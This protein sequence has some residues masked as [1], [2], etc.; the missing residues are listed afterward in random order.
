[1]KHWRIAMGVGLFSIGLVAAC[2]GSDSSTSA[3]SPD[4]STADSSRS[5]ENVGQS[6]KAPT[7]CYPALDG[8]AVRGEV[9]CLQ[10]VTGGYCTHLCQTDADCCTVPGECKSSF[11]QVCGPFEST[12]QMMCFLS[13]EQAD[14]RPAPDGGTLDDTAYCATYA[15]TD[16][17]CRSTGGG[18]KNRKVCVP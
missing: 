1:M 4:A 7:D 11:K 18:N 15:S 10:R 3:S 14:L 13:C 5:L 6:C 17:R 9:Q 8:G 12:G 16:F 2:G